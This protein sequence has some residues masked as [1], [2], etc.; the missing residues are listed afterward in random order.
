M[1]ASDAAALPEHGGQTLSARDGRRLGYDEYGARGGEACFYFHGH[2]G[3][4]LEPRLADAA[5]GEAGLRLVAL[6]RPGY[7]LSEFLPR[8]TI[9]DWA[10]DVEDVADAL[11]LDRFAVLGSSGGGPY[12]LACAHELPER[13]ARAGLISGVGPYDAPGATEGMRWQNRVGFRWAARFPPLARPIMASMERQVRRSPERT[14][15]AIASAMS[16]VDAEIVR[17]PEV[18]SAL[19]AVIAEAFRQ[20]SRGAALD[21]VLLGRPWGFSLESIQPVVFL[22]QGERDVLV[23]PAMGRRLAASIPNC[24]ATFFPGAGHLLLDHMTEIVQAFRSGRIES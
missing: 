19:A 11:G 23:P 1:P 2:P 3:S 15:D 17:R 20:G 10:R 24:R 22:W 9:R 21:I 16:G 6:D 12:A 18:R 8:R 4:R 7:G 5:A 14:L 13:V